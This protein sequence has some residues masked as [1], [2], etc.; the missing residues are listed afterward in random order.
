[1]IDRDML[2]S[3]W[4]CTLL[5]IASIWMMKMHVLA[6]QAARADE[7]HEPHELNYRRRRFR[8]RMHTSGILGILG[9]AILVGYFVKPPMAI[10]VVAVYWAA[11]LLLVA[12]VLVLACLDAIS[13]H[14]HFRR[15]RRRNES[16]QAL[17]DAKLS[18]RAPT[19]DDQSS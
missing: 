8:R 9:I 16:Q 12:W 14:L 4:M 1:M 18:R 17:L 10:M 15:V 13:T 19:N 2:P 11:V 6:W 3:L 7:S 5:V